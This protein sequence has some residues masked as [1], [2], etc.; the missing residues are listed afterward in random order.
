MWGI[1]CI[2]KPGPSSALSWGRLHKAPWVRRGGKL[3]LDAG[4]A[5][6]AWALA[7]AAGEQVEPFPGS[8]VFFVSLALAVNLARQLTAQHYRLMGLRDA[9]AILYADL[10]L[11]LASLAFCALRQEGP[12]AGEGVFLGASLLCG[13]LWFLARILVGTLVG[14]RP[15]DTPFTERALIVGAGRAGLRLCQEVR[16]HPKVRFQV[17][18]FVDD[19]PDKQGVRIEGVPVL[20]ATGQL[21]EL[22]R[23][24]GISVVILGPASAP[25][26]R[27]REL[28]REVQALGVKV[29]TVP[30]ILDF[31]GERPW[32]AQGRE[33]A[34]EELLRREPVVLDASAIRRALEGRV[35]LITGAGGS[36][37]SELA[38]R[39]AACGPSRV[40]LLGR[41]EN[42]LWE[43]EGDLARRF[44]GLPVEVALCDVRDPARLRQVF[45]AW[46]PRAVFHAAAHKHVPYLERHPEEA[47]INNI[48]GTRNVLEAA[49]AAGTAIFVNVSTDKAVNPVNA[50]GVSKRIGEHLVTLAAGHAPAGTRFVSVRFGNVLGS[51]GSVI[52]LFR[53]QIAR[54][55][56]I[57]VTHPDMVRYFM[58]IP[59]AVQLALQAGILGETAKVFALDMGAPVRIMDLAQDMARLSGYS[60]GVDI[61]IKITGARPG[62][63]LFE[64]LFSDVED[65]KADIHA[66][67]FEAVQDRPDPELLE[68]GLRALEAASALP[69]GER[70]RRILVWFRRLVP[71][72]TPSP[73]GLG[74]WLEAPR[75]AAAS[76]AARP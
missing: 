20:G 17:V 53:E 24:R 39:V 51:R 21:R 14:Y 60:A 42:S 52:P 29:R 8:L 76:G 72:Y 73:E 63:K 22:V 13:V 33:V 55:G 15:G 4:L 19:A 43:I 26:P 18:G 25:G 67:V 9:K 30:G 35:S 74:R 1:D 12:V 61:D 47:V 40:V 3:L 27:A 44:P 62:E 57:T 54:G 6:L 56:P 36:I 59:E 34:I 7:E 64:E 32:R 37:G 50:L 16:E 38:R 41:G 68:R 5:V 71:A 48:L 2:P 49:L 66:K 10:V 58:T 75:A 11:I 65:R 46:R 70:Q 28:C 69:E 23:D 45:E 31:V